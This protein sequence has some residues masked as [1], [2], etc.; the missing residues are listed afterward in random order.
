MLVIILVPYVGIHKNVILSVLTDSIQEKRSY[1]QKERKSVRNSKNESKTLEKGALTFWD[2]IAVLNVK[3]SENV[4]MAEN[5]WD[6]RS[7]K[8]PSDSTKTAFYAVAIY[9]INHLL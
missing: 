3:T 4:R 6:F 8:N 7:W 2:R 1:F 9:R 5:V